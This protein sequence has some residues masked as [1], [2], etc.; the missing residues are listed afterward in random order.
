VPS[1][2]V[3]WLAR[4]TCVP[5]GSERTNLLFMIFSNILLSELRREIGRLDRGR[6]GSLRGFSIGM[7]TA[8]F[9]MEGKEEEKK[10]RLRRKCLNRRFLHSSD[11]L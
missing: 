9:H 4:H 10:I 3:A 2:H 7:I 6:V 1:G 11:R 8:I 5:R